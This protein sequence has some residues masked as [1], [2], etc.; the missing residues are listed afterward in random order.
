MRPFPPL[1]INALRKLNQLEAEAMHRKYPNVPYPPRPNNSDKTANGLTRCIISWIRLHGYQAERISCTGRM[2]DQRK[3]YT[4]VLGH[5]RVIGSVTWIKGSM[6]RGSAD[7][8]SILQGRSVKIEVKV[9]R[10]R[11]SEAQRAY[12]A[13]VE[14]SGGVY[15]IARDFQSFFEWY[16]KEFET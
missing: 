5:R 13:Q 9:G 6:Q 12:Q 15:Y 10:D 2:I 3:T 4:D 7:I 8:S 1:P 11:Q 14:A 16:N